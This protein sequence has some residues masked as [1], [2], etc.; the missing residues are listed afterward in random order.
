MKLSSSY[1][2][3]FIEKEFRTFSVEYMSSSPFLSTMNDEQQF[4]RMRQNILRQP[5]RQQS[6]VTLSAATADLDN[7]PTDG[8]VM[9][10]TDTSENIPENDRRFDKKII[11]H[12]TH[13]KRFQPFKRNMH[14]ILDNTFGR[15]IDKGY[16]H[17]ISTTPYK[18]VL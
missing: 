18:N 9:Q 14:R 4:I 6:Q 8:N 13:E 7:H 17:G 15:Q 12:Y 16:F 11:V 1:P 2:S 10:T 3:S 5:T